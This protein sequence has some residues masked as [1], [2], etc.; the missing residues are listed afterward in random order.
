MRLNDTLPSDDDLRPLAADLEAIY[1]V[2]APAGLAARI[3][4][5]IWRAGGPVGREAQRMTVLRNRPT[6]LQ[7]DEGIAQP[8]GSRRRRGWWS[9]LA[10]TAAMFAVVALLAAVLHGGIGGAPGETAAQHFARVGGLR[11][12]ANTG[13]CAG[14]A[15]ACNVKESTTLFGQEIKILDQR[16]KAV[17]GTRVGVAVLASNGQVVILLPGTTDQAA[18]RALLAQGEF[19]ALDTGES[20]LTVGFDVR[21]TYV[22]YAQAFTGEQI[23]ASTVRAELDQ[24][25][26]KPVVTFALRSQARNQ[27]AE[28]TRKNIGQ[29]LTFTLD[30]I[31]LESAIIQAPNTTGSIEMGGLSSMADAQRLALFLRSGALPLPLQVVSMTVVYPSDAPVSCAPPTP[32]APPTTTTTEA[33]TA[34]P[35]PTTTAFP[36]VTAAPNSGSGGTTTTT[37]QPGGASTSGPTLCPTPTVGVPATPTATAIPPQATDTVTPSTTPSPTATARPSSPPTPTATPSLAAGP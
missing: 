17:L 3:D 11:I 30:G 5:A 16:F 24:A 19:A 26:G 1:D 9:G 20:A 25:S 28:F 31:V 7:R 15:D 35:S 34:T 2:P 6:P 33:A 36:T 23:D 13:P 32:A 10:A 29:H 21:T 14:S 8:R 37:S 27:F 18:A 4:A 22:L 12:V